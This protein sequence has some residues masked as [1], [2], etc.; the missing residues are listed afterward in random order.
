MTPFLIVALVIAIAIAIMGLETQLAYSWPAGTT[1]S[2]KDKILAARSMDDLSL[3]E[4]SIAEDRMYEFFDAYVPDSK[5]W[6]DLMDCGFVD[7]N[8]FEVLQCLENNGH[9]VR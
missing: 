7:K 1:E 9:P 4:F 5:E 6:K 2:Q 8:G 3:E